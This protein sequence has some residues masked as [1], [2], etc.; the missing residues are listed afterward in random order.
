MA[1]LHLIAMYFLMYV[2]IDTFDHFYHNINQFY[3]AGIMTSPMLIIEILLMGSMYENK[4]LLSILL[5]ASIASLFA[6]FIFIRGQVAV[7][8]KRFLTSM[9]PHHSSAILMCEQATITD[10]EIKKLCIEIIET[11]KEEIRKMEELLT[12]YN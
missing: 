6:F 2:M 10:E 9:I 5:G 8:D 12:E 3:M 1:A 7:D 4:K 11:Q